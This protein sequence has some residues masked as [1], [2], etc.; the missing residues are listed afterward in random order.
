MVD[1]AHY[2]P[3]LDELGI[4]IKWHVFDDTGALTA[5]CRAL[6]VCL[7]FPSCLMKSTVLM[8]TQRAR[9]SLKAMKKLRTL[10]WFE[11]P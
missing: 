6:S 1:I 3:D 7:Y 5:S 4:P 11:Y 2:C 10:N 9:R 8:A